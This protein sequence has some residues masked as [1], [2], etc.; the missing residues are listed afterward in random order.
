MLRLV[1]R[2]APLFLLISA[3]A[4]T[5]GPDRTPDLRPPTPREI[6]DGGWVLDGVTV[7]DADGSRPDRAVIVAGGRIVEVLEAGATFTNGANVVNGAGKWL[8]PGLVDAHVHLSFA[9]TIGIVGDTL[10]ANLAGQ[11]YWGVTQVVDLGGSERLFALRDRVEAGEVLG[12]HI[13]A[14]GP[15]L[16]TPGSHPCETSP[17]P[18]LCLFVTAEDA[19]AVA[20][21]LV[22]EGS[23]AVKVALADAAFTPWGT[24][25][26]DVDAVRGAV[27]A[28]VPVYAHID[29]DAD[30]LDAVDAGVAIL[31][32]PPFA[33]PMGAE[34][35][36]AAAQVDA[37]HSTVGAFA[38]V[39]DLLAGRLDPDAAD[40]LLT[41]ATRADWRAVRDGDT[42]LL[43]GWPEAS[44]EW[45][46][47]ARANVA[48]AR[49]AGVTVIPGSDA[50]YYFVPHGAGLHRELAEWVAL[51]WTPTEALAAATAESRAVLGVEGGWIRAGEPAD[52]LLLTADPTLDVAALAAIDAVILGGELHPRASLATFAVGAFDDVCL[53]DL[54]PTGERC[55]GETHTCAPACDTPY[56][57]Y[58]PACGADGWCMPRDGADAAEGVCHP[59]PTCDLYAQDCGPAWYGE[60][61]IPY[62]HDTSACW[63]AGPR[64][65]GETCS[66]ADLTR[67]CEVGAFCSWVDN[68]CYTLCDPAGPDTCPG[69]QRCVEQQAAEG[70][71]WFGVCIGR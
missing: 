37:M 53:S 40:L 14:T 19:Q 13:L 43:D 22:A 70:V 34:A 15:M 29:T 54:C 3:C 59:E 20:T 16:T 41:D 17:D 32:H 44:A 31:A 9:G 68:R 11:L 24:P 52:L 60:A 46:E 49:A 27:A 61:C 10:G 18:D 64:R 30:L 55:D 69:A 47:H 6:P 38:A 50:G 28:G 42:P 45:A 57:L 25:R 51:G 71:P 4:A 67:A 26:L 1:R 48:A 65:A 35:L 7:V 12:P 21:A 8:V 36:A 62:D 23:D 56:A 33:A 5:D 2:V 63:P 58:A 39:G 66:G